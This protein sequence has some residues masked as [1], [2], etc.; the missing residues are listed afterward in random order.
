ML[1]IYVIAILAV[2]LIFVITLFQKRVRKME[3][4]VASLKEMLKVR[5]TQLRNF[6]PY[7][8]LTGVLNAKKLLEETQS[9]IQRSIRYGVALSAIV[10]DIDKLSHI[11][12]LYGRDVGDRVL[13]R[14]AEVVSD[15]LRE[16]DFFGRYEEDSFVAVLPETHLETSIEA[17]NRL[18][19]A[20][21]E[22]YLEFREQGILVSVSMGVA[23]FSGQHETF[24]DLFRAAEKALFKGKVKGKGVIGY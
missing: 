19:E 5:D 11:N 9:E 17:A 6:L 2:A 14:V 7:D 3:R 13:R 1:W 23:Q 20:L 4:E 22:L 10:L 24:E 12:D 16:T 15:L 18:T 8:H 21:E